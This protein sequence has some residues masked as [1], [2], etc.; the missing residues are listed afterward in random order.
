MINLK[1]LWNSNYL[2][3]N[4]DLII[5]NNFNRINY[6]YPEK[7]Y[8]FQKRFEIK[9]QRS[10]E[11]CNIIPKLENFF[12]LLIQ[13][14]K[15]YFIRLL[16]NSKFPYNPQFIINAYKINQN[17]YNDQKIEDLLD[18]IILNDENNINILSNVYK[19][20]HIYQMCELFSK[21]YLESNT[22]PIG[23]KMM[24]IL[25]TKSY[26]MEK[27]ELLAIIDIFNQSSIE[28]N[29][30][31]NNPSPKDNNEA[32]LYK[33]ANMENINDPVFKELKKRQE[34]EESRKMEILKKENIKTD[35]TNEEKTKIHLDRANIK[36]NK[37]KLS[38]S[39]NLNKNK[40]SIRSKF[41]KPK[42]YIYAMD[43][44]AI[45][46]ILPVFEIVDKIES[47]VILFQERP[48]CN[49]NQ[50]NVHVGYF[51][52][53]RIKA[54]YNEILACEKEKYH[55]NKINKIVKINFFY[56]IFL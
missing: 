39:I 4:S 21:K 34:N 51:N 31:Y 15:D 56:K 2:I 22:N 5:N 50:E 53:Q 12:L 52:R 1:K 27:N 26:L 38:F 49:L 36:I 10:F 47:N 20:D 7:F 45:S 44:D 24:E 13:D 14:N 41:F 11:N 30:I 55:F 28:K 6:S 19:K 35:L 32:I 37:E 18:K 43:D 17:V 48:V 25:K 33:Y 16:S 8:K 40:A 3:K 29:S 23:K 42:V 9:K 54:Y 46:N